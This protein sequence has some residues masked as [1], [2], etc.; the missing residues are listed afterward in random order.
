MSKIVF[1]GTPASALLISD[2]LGTFAP[3][4]RVSYFEGSVHLGDGYS[5]PTEVKGG[6]YV[7]GR[8]Y[9]KGTAFSV[10]LPDEIQITL[11]AAVRTID[12]NFKMEFSQ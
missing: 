8:R 10:V 11:P 6:L 1:D 4:V 9:G 5:Q 3:Y 7:G 12:L 2:L